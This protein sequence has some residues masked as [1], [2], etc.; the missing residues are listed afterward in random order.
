MPTKMEYI[1]ESKIGENLINSRVAVDVNLYFQYMHTG[2]I[3]YNLHNIHLFKILNLF[4]YLTLA[5]GRY[6][7]AINLPL[8]L[9][10]F[11][12]FLFSP[13]GALH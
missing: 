10:Y 13:T 7:Y 12:C 3:K 11:L 8:L 6:G 5:K 2:T 4:L 9:Y 1:I